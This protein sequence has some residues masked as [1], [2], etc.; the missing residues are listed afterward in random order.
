MIP[1]REYDN[2]IS[3][4]NDKAAGGYEGGGSDW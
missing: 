4:S 2:Y 1:N 3:F